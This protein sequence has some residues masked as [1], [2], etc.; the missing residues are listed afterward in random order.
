[1]NRWEGQQHRGSRYFGFIVQMGLRL[2]SLELSVASTG[3]VRQ[4]GET[5]LKQVLCGSTILELI[6]VL[7]CR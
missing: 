5:V 1:M 2:N 7:D 6:K 3:T 4:I